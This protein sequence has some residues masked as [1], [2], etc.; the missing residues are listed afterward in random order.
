VYENETSNTSGQSLSPRDHI[1]LREHNMSQ[2]KRLSFTERDNETGKNSGHI[3]RFLSS[4]QPADVPLGTGTELEDEPSILRENNPHFITRFLSE[5]GPSDTTT[6]AW[7]TGRVFKNLIDVVTK[8]DFKS[9]W[10]NFE[11]FKIILKCGDLI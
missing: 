3:M 10:D 9:L 5:S 6:S 11:I 8:S 1:I 4:T 2:T 7:L